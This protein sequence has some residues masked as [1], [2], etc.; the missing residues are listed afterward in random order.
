MKYALV[1]LGIVQTVIDTEQDKSAYPDIVD[2]L[3]ECGD[4]VRCG[5]SYDGSS[6]SPVAEKIEDVTPRQMRQALILSGVSLSQIDD[7]IN[8]LPEP[9]KSLAMV[10]WEY[11]VAFQRH[12]PIVAQVAQMLGWNDAQLDALWKMAKIL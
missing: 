3:V 9:T 8:S 5:Y 10:E 7:A 12:R 6:F 4:D 2:Y 11:S 1:K